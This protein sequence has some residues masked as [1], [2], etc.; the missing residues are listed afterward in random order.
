MQDTQT[1]KK[2]L[3]MKRKERD[4][5]SIKEWFK[6]FWIIENNVLTIQ[7]QVK[8]CNKIRFL[9]TIGKIYK[10]VLNL[11]QIR[12]LNLIKKILMLIFLKMKMQNVI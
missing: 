7:I 5:R 2:I 8:K 12:R 1:T 3:K 9:K 11:R 4:K 6:C 10:K